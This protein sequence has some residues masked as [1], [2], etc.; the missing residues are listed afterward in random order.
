MDQSEL[1]VIGM[2]TSATSPQGLRSR[3]VDYIGNDLHIPYTSSR[4]SSKLNYAAQLRKNLEVLHQNTS[5]EQDNC[6]TSPEVFECEPEDFDEE[7]TVRET[8]RS[9]VF[10]TF[11]NL[12]NSIIGGGIVS[13][14]Y[15]V[16]S[17]GFL[18]GM[19][20]L[21]SVAILAGTLLHHS[22]KGMI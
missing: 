6:M 16:Q 20:L 15:A 19:F 18:S 2:D 17:C 10:G 8:R 9:G 7:G 22:I 21:I 14:P 13:I 4:T 5:V 12:A 11:A 1:P 3:M